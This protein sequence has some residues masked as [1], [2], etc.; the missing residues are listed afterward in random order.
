MDIY[1]PLSEVKISVNGLRLKILDPQNGAVRKLNRMILIMR[2]GHHFS[3]HEPNCGT[4]DA[5]N[6]GFWVYLWS[7]K[8]RI[9]WVLEGILDDPNLVCEGGNHGKPLRFE[10]QQIKTCTIWK[11]EWMRCAIHMCIQYTVYSH[12]AAQE[13]ER[14]VPPCSFSVVTDYKS[15]S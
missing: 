10:G 14:S 8:L 13:A 4:G 5:V 15:R 3:S 7:G 2:I 1:G 11:N 12:N 6:L 9:T